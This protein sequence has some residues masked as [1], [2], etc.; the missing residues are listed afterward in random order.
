[1]IHFWGEVAVSKR[2][3][4]MEMEGNKKF[5]NWGRGEAAGLRNIFGPP[6]T[7]H[8]NWKGPNEYGVGPGK[9]RETE[10]KQ[11]ILV[12]SECNERAF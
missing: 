1:M 6:P 9:G 12:Q 8:M 3:K 4:G 5:K 11:N 2:G 7:C 10:K